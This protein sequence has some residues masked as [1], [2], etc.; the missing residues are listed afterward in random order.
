[1]SESYLEIGKGVFGIQVAALQGV[2][3][4]MDDS[5]C[6][7]VDILFNTSGRVVVLGVGKSGLIGHKIASTFA[8]TGTPS[9]NIHASDAVHGDLGMIRPEDVGL[10][11][12]YSGE[13]EELLR[14]IPF[15]K[16][17]GNKIVAMTGHMSS[18]LAKFADVVLDIGIDR[19]SC[20]NNLAPTTS[21]TATLVMGDALASA[22]IRARNFKP[23]DF[24]R[25]HPGGSLGRRLLTRIRDVMHTENLPFVRPDDYL[26]DVVGTMTSRRLGVALVMENEALLG[27]ITDGDLRR[28]LSIKEDPLSRRARDIMTTNP[29]TIAQDH[30]LPEAEQLMRNS[31]VKALVVVDAPESKK[32]VGVML[33]LDV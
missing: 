13:T 21:T 26:R 32:V 15:L 12:S 28:A 23:I 7:A 19:E 8:S 3:S 11:I 10:L 25:F 31:K 9:I 18:M 16:N 4:R 6:Q 24:A 30:T 2:A 20:P 27:L 17:Q 29:L 33:I 22:L 14:V 1:M 5:F